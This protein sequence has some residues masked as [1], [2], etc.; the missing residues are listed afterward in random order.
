MN[1]LSLAIVTT[2]A[3]Y[4]RYLPDW[5]ASV[6][7]LSLKPAEVAL[8][9]HGSDADREAGAAAVAVVQAAGI[10][11]R[12]EHSPTRL[13]FGA[14]RNRAVA[15]TT[16][17]WVMHLDADDTVLPHCLDDVAALA[18]D[19]DVVTVGYERTGDLDSGPRL[20]RKTYRSLTGHMA[21]VNPT[22][23][24]GCSPF[25]RALW[26]RAPY[27][28]GV[29]QGGWDTALWLGFAH[30]GARF[31]PTSRP[32]FHYRQHADSLFNT[33]R[34]SGWPAERTGQKLQSLRRGDT[35]VSVIVPR[36][37]DGGG[38]RDAAWAW[39]RARYQQVHPGWQ[40]LEGSGHPGSWRKGEAVAQALESATGRV[41]VV[42]DADCVLPAAALREAVAL[43]DAGTPWVVPHTM[44]HR[45]NPEQAAG[46]LAQAP[47]YWADPPT[48]RLARPAYQ[49]VAGGGVVVVSRS[50]YLATRGIPKQFCGWGAEDETLACI[51]ETLCGPH[52][53]LP[54][55]LVHLWHP[56]QRRQVS[57]VG[58]RGLFQHFRRAL[59]DIPAMWALV[60]GRGYPVARSSFAPA[61]RYANLAAQ[62]EGMTMAGKDK[63]AGPM[64]TNQ[65][66]GQNR[67]VVLKRADV[68]AQ[69]AAEK[70]AR[71][72]ERQKH[73]A[74]Y[75]ASLANRAAHRAAAAAE[76][77]AA[78]GP[79]SNKMLGGHLQ[80]TDVPAL[81]GFA[82]KADDEAG[83]E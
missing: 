21:L 53:R 75:Q 20:R 9:T 7:G 66:T 16:T 43:V 35:G 48:Q 42:A 51:L 52:R 18:P 59:G 78:R 74:T 67:G 29:L 28:E 17:E 11:A 24:S 39:L 37:S 38:P 14:A 68:N 8:V 64:F 12:Q 82:T 33:R 83:A 2:C 45:L 80:G 41:L 60:N 62:R 69:A 26:E 6:A 15:L 13:D 57:T 1:P 76:A 27:L 19:A 54:Y 77:K 58:N 61:D 36:A 30:L 65:G 22:P 23:A 47:D 72:A 79:R 3:G 55:P 40:V 25:R 71:K 31:R 46:W 10:P 63:L 44:V 73:A 5:A 4:G 34:T 70:E 81:A 56:A 50:D 32:G 49:G